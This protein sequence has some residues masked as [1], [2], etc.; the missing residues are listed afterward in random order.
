MRRK[1][2]VLLTVGILFFLS[3]IS[4]AA[5]EKR[6]ALVIGNGAYATGG[7]RNPVNDAADVAAALKRLG[8]DVTLK[9]NVRLREMD[10]A[11][12]NFGGRLKRGGVGLFYFAGHGIQ[13]NGI[14]YL[15]PVGA[16]INKESDVKYEA[17]DANKILDEMAYANNGLNILI[18]DACRDNPFGRSFRSQSRGLAIISTAPEG[19]FIS[20]AT[21]PGQVA[22]DGKGRN[23]PYTAALLKYMKEPGLPI[24]Q[25]FKKVR[26]RLS[27]VRQ[28]PWE[29]SSLKGDFYF[30][31]DAGGERA[32]VQEPE[33]SRESG[34]K[35]LAYAPPR[36][37]KSTVGGIGAFAR[38]W[39]WSKD[40]HQD[41]EY[42]ET[43]VTIETPQNVK[44]ATLFVS[45][46]YSQ[47][48]GEARANVYI[49]GNA[50]ITPPDSRHDRS[51]WWVGNSASLGQLIGSFTTR[52][53]SN[54]PS[55]FDITHIVQRLPRDTYYVAIQNLSP[56]DIGIGSVYIEMVTE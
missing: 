45:H 46:G 41:G 50:Q 19:T 23:S 38:D 32:R 49:S 18:L 53:G 54:P 22:L 37:V 8:F 20:Y 15:I 35:V 16:D 43:K 31:P 17:V 12:E 1:P 29:L 21:G 56:A 30:Q 10:E 26:L 44:K 6:T 9:K 52:Y 2:E 47:Q 27:S 42:G 13:A 5:A 24:E 4:P 55:R 3:S 28:T 36:T 51:K 33:P 25:V 48:S 11:I 7:L 14:N 39:W 40:R 34:E